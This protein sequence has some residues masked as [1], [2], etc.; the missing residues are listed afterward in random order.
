MLQ[1]S[2]VDD[3]MDGEGE[4]VRAKEETAEGQ[5]S[6]LRRTKGGESRPAKRE[7][8]ENC[9]EKHGRSK[10]WTESVNTLSEYGMHAT[11]P[12]SSPKRPK[13]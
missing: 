11:A 1:E 4:A 5:T 7:E 6:A 2:A 3:D 9:K 13:N 10:G 12:P 8:T